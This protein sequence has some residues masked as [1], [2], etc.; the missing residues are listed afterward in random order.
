ML[1]SQERLTRAQCSLLLGNPHIRV[2]FNRLGTLK[3]LPNTENQSNKQ[4]F[5]VI[6]GSK[7]QKKAVLR[8]ALRRKLY[9]LFRYFYASGG[10][11]PIQGMLYVSK[12][13]YELSFIEL[14]TLFNDLIAK[15][16]KN[17]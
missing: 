5:S 12:T 15:T 4:G 3:Y 7:T 17:P 11:N 16:Q 14:N 13:A 9:T 8:N 2:V 6:T 10:K 1:P